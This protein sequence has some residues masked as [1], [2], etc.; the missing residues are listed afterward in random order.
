MLRLVS[1]PDGILGRPDLAMWLMMTP[2]TM[3]FGY[4]P[5]FIISGVAATPIFEATAAV[6][7]LFAT[8]SVAVG[9]IFEA[10]RVRI[11]ERRK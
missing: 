11:N 4:I 10:A 9:P 6:L 1:I 5:K 7:P 3:G 8:D 2:A